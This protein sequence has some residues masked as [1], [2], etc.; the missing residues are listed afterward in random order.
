MV[1]IRHLLRITRAVFSQCAAIRLCGSDEQWVT[2]MSFLN[3]AVV[4]LLLSTFTAR[5]V[6]PA[7]SLEGRAFLDPR[8][9]ANFAR[10]NLVGEI[11]VLRA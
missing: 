3:V 6:F 11:L 4:G 8:H 10:R 7:I 1:S 5:F 2:V 9:V